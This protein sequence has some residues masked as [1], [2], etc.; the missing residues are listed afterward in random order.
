M[1]GYIILLK[2]LKPYKVR[3]FFAL[4]CLYGATA[5]QLFLPWIIKDVIDK[6]LIDKNLALL[7]LIVMGIIGMFIL[8]GFFVY[9]QQYLMAYI[10]QRVM[11]D[12]RYRLFSSMMSGRGLSYYEKKKTGAIMSFFTNDVQALQSAIVGHGLDFVTETFILVFSVVSM[13]YIDWKMTLLLFVTVPLLAFSV[14]RLGKK[15]RAAG[16]QVQAELA[17]LTS[18]LQEVLSGVRVVKSFA[19]EEHENERFSA[20]I[21]RNLKAVMRATRATALLTPIVEFLATIGVAALIWYGGNEVI[22]GRL[23]AG[24]LIAFLIYSINLS[25]PLKRIS[26]TWANL[27]LSMAAADRIFGELDFIP[28]VKDADNATSLVVYQGRVEFEHVNFSYNPNEPVLNDFNFTAE[29]GQVVALVGHSGAGKTTLVN[30]IPRFYDIQSGAIRI[31]GQDIRNVTQKSLREA[32]GI[33]PQET[34]LFSGN[35]REN[36]RYGRLDATDDEIIQAAKAANALEF[37]DKMPLGFDT[38]VGERGMMLSG[39][40]RQRIAIARAILKNPQILILDE[41][42]SALDTESERLVQAALDVLLKSRTSFIIAHRLSTIFK[43]DII[44]VMKNGQ[45]AEKGTHHDL[46][47][48]DGIY[49]KLCETQFGKENMEEIKKDDQ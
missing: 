27:Q 36:I 29:P 6:V 11:V 2:Y 14:D 9:G 5:T 28:E 48:K 22:N 18:L 33:V 24:E 35:I 31:D 8:R 3:L 45:I 7:N 46:L 4:I 43:A 10:V 41:A 17:E 16:G 23:T 26:R 13:T 34:L 21:V 25:N 40:Q 42:T 37:I 15:I 20:Q 30:L 32:I 1:K 44:L 12:I 39:G 19:R 38:P 49:K 47:E